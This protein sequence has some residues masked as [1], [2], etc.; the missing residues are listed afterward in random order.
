[1]TQKLKDR[2]ALITGASHGIGRAVALAYAKEGAHILALGRSQGALEELDDEIT[3]LGAQATLVPMNLN[4]EKKILE[5]GATIFERWGKLDVLVA[6]A[7]FLPPLTPLAHVEEK[8]WK[9]TLDINLTANWRLLRSLDVPLKQSEAGRAIFVTTSA[10]Q[11]TYPFWGPYAVSK[12]GLEVLAKTYAEENLNTNIKV[13]LINPGAT[14][15]NMRA[16]AMPG[17]DPET[18]PSPEDVAQHFIAPATVDYAGSSEIINL[19]DFL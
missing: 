11:K 7:G 9:N 12:I 16:A 1:M 17:E 10:T 19:R 3:Q 15:T 2:L 6:N 5:L 4:D 14:A 13:T 18:L 8:D